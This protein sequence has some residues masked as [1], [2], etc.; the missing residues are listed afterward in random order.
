VSFA[1]RSAEPDDLESLVALE[2]AAFVQDRISRRQLRHLLT[3]ANARVLLA[4]APTGEVLGDAVILFSRATATARL[5]SVA[6]HPDARGQ[7]VGRRLL[8]EAETVSWE[9]E[10]A[11]IRAE[12]RKDN[13]ASIGLFESQGYRRFGEYDDYYDDH[14]DAW[15][16]EKQLD[17]RLR[18]SLAKVPFYRQSLDFTCGPAALMMALRSL[19]SAIPLDRRTELRLWREA[20]TVF[21]TTGPGGCGP[22]GLA[23]AAH[24]RGFQ[25]EVL[26]SSTGAHLQE[27]VR[28][29]E[30]REV[31]AL[32]QE[33]MEAEL[34]DRSV[35]IRFGR[36]TLAQT[37]RRFREGQIPL[38]L[39][40][41]WQIYQERTPHWVVVTGFDEHFVYVHDPFVD[42]KEGETVSDS[43]H[44]P[45]GRSL[46]TRMTRYGRRGLQAAVYVSRPTRK[47][48]RGR[49]SARAGTGSEGRTASKPGARAKARARTES[50]Q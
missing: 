42:E 20:T 11:W 8:E 29:D 14:M 23:L 27:T 40:S 39:I 18:P 4:E 34:R 19:D 46:F 41:S 25:V 49:T 9:R 28:S 3:R 44:M 32:V 10:R 13:V 5:Y 2:E 6:V 43:I 50:E 22:L 48:N 16:Y 1:I 12:I 47:R 38:I 31:M 35:P 36:I 37:E 24:N 15:R 21:M 45:I 26:V 7:G 17:P 33:D 30:K